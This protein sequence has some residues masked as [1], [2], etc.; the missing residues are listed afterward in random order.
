M[1]RLTS[2]RDLNLPRSETRILCLSLGLA[3]T[4][5]PCAYCTAACVPI[6]VLPARIKAER[7]G[8][9]SLSAS[10]IPWNEQIAAN[11]LRDT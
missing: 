6:V 7:D 8:F 5:S 9:S 10:R 3:S 11:S 1:P 2:I 4:T